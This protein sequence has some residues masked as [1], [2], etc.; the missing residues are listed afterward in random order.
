MK[1]KYLS[2]AGV[3]R[4][5][6]AAL[7]EIEQT[8]PKDWI[9]YAGFQFVPPYGNPLD[10]DLLILT[11]HRLV[12]V[13]LKNWQGV[14]AD[15]ASQWYA[16]DAFRGR[17]PVASITDKARRLHSFLV[18]KMPPADVPYAEGIVVTCHPNHT[19][20][21]S[22][23]ERKRTLR[24]EEFLAIKNTAKYEKLFPFIHP[25]YNRASLNPLSNN[26][27]TRFEMFFSNQSA[28]RP[29]QAVVQ[30]YRQQGNTPE[31]EH[32]S[33]LYQEFFGKHVDDSKARGLI[34]LW[35]FER[36]DN[37]NCTQ[38][39]RA[40]VALREFR[41]HEHV[42]E[43]SPSMRDSMLEPIGSY[44]EED[45]TTH[46]AEAYRLPSKL[47]RLD[48]FIGRR[49]S[50]ERE[51]RELLLQ[52]VLT[53]YADLHDLGIAHRDIGTHSLWVQEP[54]QFVMSSFA[55][56]YFPERETVGVR[57][58]QIEVGAV[59]LP[60]DAAT[61]G[62]G[63]PFRRDIFMLG[64]VAYFVLFG[65]AAPTKE[66][67]PSVASA[68][69]VDTDPLYPWLVKMLA[70]VPN[71]RPARASEALDLLNEHLPKHVSS[72]V[73][74]VDLEPYKSLASPAMYPVAQQ[75]SMNDGKWVYRTAAGGQE[76]VVKFWTG[77]Q[78]DS[79]RPDRN[80]RLLAFLKQARAMQSAPTDDFARI[81]DF[82]IGPLGLALVVAWVDGVV[83]KDWL[84]SMSEPVRR[85]ELAVE[86]LRAVERLHANGVTHGDLNP[87]NL[88]VVDEASKPP[89][90]KFVDLPDLRPNGDEGITP[91]YSPSDGEVLSTEERDRYASALIAK[92]LIEATPL[93]AGCVEEIHRA[94]GQAGAGVP[95]DLIASSIERAVKPPV[96]EDT[97]KFELGFLG[98]PPSLGEG[99]LFTSDNGKF[100][101]GVELPQNT[102]GQKLVVF[103]VTGV[104]EHLRI[105]VNHETRAITAIKCLPLTHVEYVASIRRAKFN[106]ECELKWVHSTKSDAAALLAHLFEKSLAVGALDRGA[107]EDAT[108]EA[109]EANAQ[110][111][112]ETT[113]FSTRSMWQAMADSEMENAVTVTVHGTSEIDPNDSEVLLVPCSLDAGT[114]DF[115]PT[116]RVSVL[117]NQLDRTTA[118]L[119][120]RW[121]ATLDV[122]KST[123]VCLALRDRKPS[124]ST[125]AGT[126]YRLRGA[127]EEIA[128]NRKQQA[129]K[130]ILAGESLIRDL[131]DY[132]DSGSDRKPYLVKVP[133]KI[134][135]K[136]YGLNAEQ[137]EALEIAI[138]HGPVSLL[139][140]PPGTGKTKF[141]SAVVHI[142]LTYGLAQRILLVSQ[143]HEAV[144][145]AL[146]KLIELAKETGKPISAVRVGAESQLSPPVR[147][148]HDYY[149]QQAFR[150]SFVAE[151]KQRILTAAAGLSLQTALLKDAID[152]YL[153]PG[154]IAKEI[155]LVQKR[156]ESHTKDPAELE[157]DQRRLSS[158]T[159]TFG[160][161][162]ARR[163]GTSLNGR[164]PSALLYQLEKDL[165]AAHGGV[166]PARLEKL[167]KLV[168]L[169][170]E[171]KQVLGNPQAN[172]SAFLTRTCEVV[173]GTCVGIG[174]S[175]YG[176]TECHY[177]WVVI[178]EAARSSP[179]ELAVAMQAG[180]RI[181][182]V[183]DHHQ[184]PPTYTPD[185]AQEVAKRLQQT[186]VNLTDLNDF[187]CAFE[188]PYG[189][190]VGRTLTRQYRMAD[191]I[192][193][194]VSHGFYDGALT[195]ARNPP[196][197]DYSRI[198][199]VFSRQVVW[200]DT[201]DRGRDARERPQRDGS[202][203]N[204]A[205]AQAV[206]EVLQQIADSGEL[207]DTLR[208]DETDELPIGVICMYAA[209]RD[210]IQ[211]RLQKAEWAT[212][213]RELIKV[214]TVDSYQGKENQIVLLSLVR[215]NVEGKTG[216][217]SLRARINVAVSRAKDRLLIFSSASMWTNRPNSGGGIVLS[218]VQRLADE[219]RA[220]I[221]ASRTLR[222]RE[223]V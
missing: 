204:E 219:D 117:A 9:G 38:K 114:L 223:A 188:S 199:S 64:A 146:T 209:Q 33:A 174:R 181:L 113:R 93:M 5:E 13:E 182:L 60:E 56:A 141:I 149:Q 134:D 108:E 62:G 201:S 20:Q 140:G 200:I 212:A 16:N 7:R 1:I 216:F 24:L 172:F 161:L 197:V 144:N 18:K 104:T 195:T 126:Q 17:S 59:K 48:E 87:T 133:E 180:R 85:A 163:Y 50:F 83:L 211:S 73:A 15:N 45:V 28:V 79:K 165:V 32:P 222:V 177:D 148:L 156:L 125:D 157:R 97:Q 189:Q 112:S 160:N 91:A 36:L 130:R 208:T 214:G 169:S 82:G 27:R 213:L 39:E 136:A 68:P 105:A 19:L 101:V 123:D 191:A 14:I 41:I 121:V 150:E 168:D 215:S 179:T 2:P 52:A 142:L 37:G 107:S 49:P 75:L 42:R 47:E 76:C 44:S 21:L 80:E 220:A 6:Q 66:G 131:P 116:E 159:E 152:L 81:I 190:G 84:A 51:N 183:G 203:I 194:L 173:A 29:R 65:Q 89:Q 185:F 74:E 143:S 102:V 96:K 164:D 26:I 196:T 162:A 40:N 78:F 94:L 151:V 22:A 103:H 187:K 176:I 110:P 109:T 25:E 167:K 58:A 69:G 31:F 111:V 57:R 4:D 198:A 210:L 95:I 88:L 72:M 171:F 132:F 175:S 70:V 8:L 170:V 137:K 139:Q 206:L 135:W 86:L 12:L 138:G 218:Q 98:R 46:F 92:E 155:R 184:L 115:D 63:D 99:D 128:L 217:L 158:L 118:E 61:P 100:A 30:N 11:P 127:L 67:V 53:R 202:Y 147:H 10:I 106:I 129:M 55:A 119:R 90:V 77:I 3:L 192:G 178:D 23:P 120:W 122:R 54:A 71:D 205:E 145:H 186:R 193:E 207:V 154:Q 34:R 221:L 153:G 35:D 166:S 124:F 43:R